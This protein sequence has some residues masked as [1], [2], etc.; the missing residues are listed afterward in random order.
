MKTLFM[1]TVAM[2]AQA[3]M[4]Q[5]GGIDRTGQFLGPV[6]E[7]TGP[8]GNYVQLSYASVDP[9]MKTSTGGDPLTHYSSF[10]FAYKR[11][12]SDAFSLTLLHDQPF[13]A[14][15]QYPS[16]PVFGGAFADI[17]T[18]AVTMIG[19]Y[20]FGNGFSVHGGPRLQKIFG[21]VQT[22]QRLSASSDFDL[23]Y[24]VG[25]A[26]EK[27]EIALRVALTYNSEIDNKLSGTELSAGSPATASAFTVTSPESLNLEFQSG[28]AEDTL[29]FGSI[30]HVKWEGFNLTT[31]T[32]VYA[33][34]VDD[35]MTY[36]LGLGR[37]FNDTWSGAVILGYEPAGTRPTNT[38]LQPYTGSQSV[39]LAMTYT[40]DN[41]NITGGVTYAKLGD[42]ILGGP[43]SWSDGEALAGGIRV[44]LSF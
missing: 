26:Y 24:A 43:V 28:V 17:G 31:P 1:M 6:F 41:L 23:G 37:K 9:S 42:Q 27:P 20:E 38:A 14:G 19:H 44:G 12:L 29:I 40:Q 2:V 10:G 7:A 22:T 4:A 15:V 16:G 3:G 34:F 32:L 39:G 33:T 8:G 11:Q 5:A 21:S 13:G 25:V 18:E 36:S 35:T 30:R